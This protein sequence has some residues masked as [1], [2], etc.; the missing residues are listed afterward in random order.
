[1]VSSMLKHWTVLLWCRMQDV[2]SDY[3]PRRP[4]L[5]W[6]PA[7]CCWAPV[8][9]PHN[10]TGAGLHIVHIISVSPSYALTQVFSLKV[11]RIS[12]SLHTSGIH[13]QACNWWHTHN[14][15]YWIL[16]RFILYCWSQGTPLLRRGRRLD[17]VTRRHKTCVLST[18]PS[19]K[20]QD[21]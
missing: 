21:K 2:L 20:S 16:I 1:M 14:A 7:D 17:T 9:N 15:S 6:R 3:L 11:K 10:N 12:L 13:R 18:E 4:Y 19:I 8:Y 5:L